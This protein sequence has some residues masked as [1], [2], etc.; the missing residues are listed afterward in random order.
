[1]LLLLLPLFKDEDED[2]EDE[3]D[4]DDDEDDDDEEDEEDSDADEGAGARFFR[5]PL[6]LA[7]LAGGGL[8]VPA[9]PETPNSTS[10]S[11][12]APPLALA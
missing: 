11:S 5:P 8:R 4:E 7:G 6:G 10:S 3:D 2:E 1:M 12:F 9:P